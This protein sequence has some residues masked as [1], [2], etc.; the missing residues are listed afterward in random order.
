M[1]VEGPQPRA[2]PGSS[3]ASLACIPCRT[4]HIRCD[5]TRPY[6]RRCSSH[7]KECRYEK[8]RRGGLDREALAAR[9]SRET[10]DASS[11]GSSDPPT[12]LAS[13]DV[14]LADEQGTHP[15]GAWHSPWAQYD[16]SGSE[17][18]EPAPSILDLQYPGFDTPDPLL[19]S[20][21]AADDPLIEL[22]YEHF[23][24]FHPY[25]LPL[26][27]LQK[28]LRDG[29]RRPVLEPLVSVIR[30]IGSIY[31]RSS[32]SAQLKEHARK[33][34][35]DLQSPVD[36]SEKAFMTQSRL[37]FSIA[38]YWS[39]DMEES[40]SVLDRAI[41]DAFDLGMNRR[42]FAAENSGGDPV[43][44]ESWRRTW[45]QLYI[46]DAYYAAIRRS[47]KFLAQVEATTDLP[48]SESEYHLGVS[49]LL[50]VRPSIA[51]LLVP[52]SLTILFS[53]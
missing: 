18:R 6:C 35:S 25:I 7:G 10:R 13:V 40:R 45:W 46:V 3:R 21:G 28:L 29:N 52:L 47:P 27:H 5:A 48:C 14:A 38:L 33:C 1:P 41:H 32:E 26:Q 2:K 19:R 34:N 36:P 11:P 23:H 51:L 22:Y 43:L 44:A 8:S 24:G 50:S 42:E 15:G 9:R 17:P 53:Y 16:S 31:R 30:F 4:R 37:L 12:G 39:T 20:A 49:T